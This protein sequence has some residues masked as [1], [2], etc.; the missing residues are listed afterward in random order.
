MIL[1]DFLVKSIYF[2]L[3]AAVS[4]PS[5]VSIPAVSHLD[6]LGIKSKKVENC[7]SISLLVPSMSQYFKERRWNDQRELNKENDN[8]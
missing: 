8:R 5:R 2:I 6:I 3:Q 7:F 1:T 4:N